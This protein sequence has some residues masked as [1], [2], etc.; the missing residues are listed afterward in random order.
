MTE[1][2]KGL[3]DGDR[4][5]HLGVVRAIAEEPFNEL[6]GAAAAASENEEHPEGVK[7][8]ETKGVK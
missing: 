4:A 8:D 5:W 6:L 1:T 3:S 7:D 2:V